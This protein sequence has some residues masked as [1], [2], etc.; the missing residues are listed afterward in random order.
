MKHFEHLLWWCG[1]EQ[2]EDT[3]KQVRED[4]IR[5]SESG[6]ERADGA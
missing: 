2:I 4:V 3:L 5:K 6:R 1:F